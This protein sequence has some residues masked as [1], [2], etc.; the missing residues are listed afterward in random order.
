[1]NYLDKKTDILDWLS[2]LPEGSKVVYNKTSTGWIMYVESAPAHCYYID[3]I[4]N[5]AADNTN[6]DL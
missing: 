4:V 6:F 5:R 2:S 3:A 1:M